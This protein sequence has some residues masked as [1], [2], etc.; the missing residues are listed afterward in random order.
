MLLETFLMTSIEEEKI[1]AN[2]ALDLGILLNSSPLLIS[3]DVDKLRKAD[4]FLVDLLKKNYLLKKSIISSCVH[5][6][7][8]LDE[9]TFLRCIEY[10]LRH[11]PGSEL[12]AHLDSSMIEAIS[13][14]ISFTDFYS[15]ENEHI[16]V[17]LGSLIRI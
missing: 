11:L 5:Y 16:S 15:S 14:K 1:D 10:T 13:D 9:S 6:I 17:K 7:D 12:K 8:E 3:F 4:I 2:C